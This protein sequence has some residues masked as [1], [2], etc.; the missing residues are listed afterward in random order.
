M[1]DLTRVSFGCLRP[2]C[3]ADCVCS[4]WADAPA[5]SL[6]HRQPTQQMILHLIMVLQLCFHSFCGSSLTVRMPSTS[7]AP[8]FLLSLGQL[9]RHL[10]AMKADTLSNGRQLAYGSYKDCSRPLRRCLKQLG[11]GSIDTGF[12]AM[13][14]DN[15]ALEEVAALVDVDKQVPVTC[16]PNMCS[17]ELSCCR[18]MVCMSG[19]TCRVQ[20]IFLPLRVLDV[21]PDQ[22]LHH[23]RK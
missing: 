8:G 18:H 12:N 3:I 14:T 17:L 15:K 1:L 20:C 11:S 19:M 23:D 5:S 13:K 4:S 7:S 9:R 21:T 10:Q 6:L 2:A 16:H 22:H